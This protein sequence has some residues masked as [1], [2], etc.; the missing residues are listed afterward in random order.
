MKTILI[1]GG[2]GFLGLPLSNYL[3]K[4]YYVTIFQRKKPNSKNLKGIKFKSVDLSN[5][6]NCRR[7]I[8]DFNIVINCAAILKGNKQN[9]LF[10]QNMK[11]FLFSIIACLNNNIK[12]YVFIS[13]NNAI[14]KNDFLKRS[15]NKLKFKISDGYTLAKI[16][17]EFFL[18]KLKNKINIKII[19]PSNIYGP[20]YG[21]G[22]IY[23]LIKKIQ[24][25]KKKKLILNTNPHN[26]RNFTHVED[27]A[28]CIAFVL[29]KNFDKPINITNDIKISIKDL[30]LII[31]RVLKKNTQ[32]IY[33]YEKGSLNHKLFKT[34]YIKKTKW[35]DKFSL[36]KGI[37]NIV[38][39][40]HI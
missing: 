7:Y 37:K 6:N 3:K 8:K 19:R 25:N 9:K 31:K 36:E 16:M 18:S 39:K 15:K 2:G 11:I 13:S 5:L 30:V 10:V 22:V 4:K 17:S 24:F 34:T 14:S 21:S 20:N 27:C 23:D 33:R 40:S 32:I 38:E 12:N 28:K 26:N 35:K 29:K 1:L